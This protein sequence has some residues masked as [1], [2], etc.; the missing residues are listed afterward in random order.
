MKE[1]LNLELGIRIEFYTSPKW[2]EFIDLNGK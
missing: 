2:V 1:R